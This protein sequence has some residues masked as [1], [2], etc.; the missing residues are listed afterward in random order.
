MTWERD[1]GCR[2]TWSSTVRSI[3]RVV[4]FQSCE[5]D[6]SYTDGIGTT[7]CPSCVGNSV[8]ISPSRATWYT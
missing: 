8:M 5:A 2:V 3:G 1:A 6:R 7:I 4:V